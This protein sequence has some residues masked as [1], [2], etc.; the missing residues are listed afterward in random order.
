MQLECF[1][2]I[3]LNTKYLPEWQHSKECMGH[4]RNMACNYQEK[5]IKTRRVCETRKPQ[6]PT[7]SKSDKISMSYILTPPHP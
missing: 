4:L 2:P 6:A 3:T 1:D 5:C 7:K